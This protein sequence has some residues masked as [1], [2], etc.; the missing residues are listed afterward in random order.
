MINVICLG[1]L[2]I[3]F[4]STDRDTDL[5]HSSGFLK[6][7]GGAPANVA[8]GV[9]RLGFTS[10]FIGKVGDDPFGYYLEEVLKNETVNTDYLIFDDY[11]R[12][13]L[14]YVALKSDGHRD[15]MFYRNPGADMLLNEGEI[16]EQYFKG[17]QIFHFGSI[18]LG[19]A[20]CEKATL[21]AIEY[22]KKQGGI[23]SY[24]PNLRLSLWD[25]EQFARE[26]INS[27]FPYADIVK[28]SDEEY[29]FITGADTPEDCAKYILDMG[30]K[31]VVITL[32]GNGCYYSDGITSGYIAGN[33]VNVVEITGAGDSFVASLLCGVCD[34]MNGKK[35]DI[36][37][38]DDNFIEW[39]KFSNM[40]GALATTKMGAIPSLPTK[41]EVD[42]ALKSLK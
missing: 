36:L 28:I 23:I 11:A 33:K 16:D 2:L 21:K 37:T 4:I 30:A 41:D 10:G 38:I 18:S 7:P 1:E 14:S 26:K 12:T 40:A 34:R 32:G 9:S 24:D 20:L 31:I 35:E 15:C 22:A 3:D 25:N 5:I 19:S 29:R 8:V 13:T 17:N 39:I 27:G 6:A 42:N